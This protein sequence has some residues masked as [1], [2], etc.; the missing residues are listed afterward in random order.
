MS[1]WFRNTAWNE[2]I[3]SA[4]HDRLHRAG[5][6]APYSGVH[7]ASARVQSSISADR[8]PNRVFVVRGQNETARTAVVLLWKAW[9]WLETDRKYPTQQAFS[10]ERRSREFRLSAVGRLLRR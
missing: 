7:P 8:W 3:E 9:D 1:E 2:A 5:G 4:F 10:S 6:V